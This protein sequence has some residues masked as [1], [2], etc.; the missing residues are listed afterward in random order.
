MLLE[1]TIESRANQSSVNAFVLAG[2]NV[3][4]P[5]GYF[6]EF[7]PLAAVFAVP[8]AQARC[9]GVLQ[10]RGTIFPVFDAASNLKDRKPL[11]HQSVLLAGEGQKAAA[12]LVSL[13]PQLL[14][15]ERDDMA[16]KPSSCAFSESLVGPAK[17]LSS[18][19]FGPLNEAYWGLDLDKLFAQ[20][21]QGS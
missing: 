14:T 12:L 8:H 1:A 6:L 21:S 11:K 9:V 3:F 19:N 15:I 2:V 13:A 5:S 16:L 20:L 7:V 17:T 4:V 10:R 18:A